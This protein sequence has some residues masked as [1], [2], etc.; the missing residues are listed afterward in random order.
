MNPK[1]AYTNYM[2]HKIGRIRFDFETFKQQIAIA[3][4]KHLNFGRR[5]KR[6]HIFDN[7]ALFE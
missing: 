1:N 7:C 3:G 4:H 6:I 2:Q 5:K